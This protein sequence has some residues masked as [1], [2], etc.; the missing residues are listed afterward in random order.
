[1]CM[2]RPALNVRMRGLC[3]GAP[4]GTTWHSGS[5]PLVHPALV[6]PTGSFNWFIQSKTSA[7]VVRLAT[8]LTSSLPAVASGRRHLL[9]ARRLLDHLLGRLVW[10][11]LITMEAA[12]E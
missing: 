7:M 9:L 8:P 12:A 5:Y 4:G 2:T 10:E 3:H 6:H 11:L 1:M